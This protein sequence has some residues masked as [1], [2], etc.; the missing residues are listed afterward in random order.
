[1]YARDAIQSALPRGLQARVEEYLA[2]EAPLETEPGFKRIAPD[3]SIYATGNASP[4]A[5]RPEAASVI[6]LDAEEEPVIF[7]R[8]EPMTLRY[9]EIIDIASDRRVIT[10]IEFLSPANKT[11]AGAKQYREKQQRLVHGQINLVEIDL[12]RKGNWVLAAD[13]SSYPTMLTQP[14]RICVTRSADPNQFEGYRATYGSPLPSIRVPLR[15]MDSDIRLPLQSILNKAYVNGR[16]GDTLDYSLPPKVS[17]TE[18]GL[19]EVNILLA[20]TTAS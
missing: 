17:M 13:K 2:V 16:Y 9:I 18:E 6:T 11:D 3:I 14:Y 10:A 7:Q 8:V 19:A 5:T 12:L 1:M 20:K 15:P 4:A